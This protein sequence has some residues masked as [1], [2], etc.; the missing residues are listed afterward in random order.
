MAEPRTGPKFG[1]PTFKCNICSDSIHRTPRSAST[2]SQGSCEW[3]KH[4][5][6]V[7]W[8]K[9]EQIL[10]LKVGCP[11]FGPV[12]DSVI[13]P[14]YLHM[15]DVEWGKLPLSRT[16]P[17]SEQSTLKCN[18]CSNFTNRTW[19]SWMTKP[20]TGFLWMGWLW[21]CSMGRIEADIALES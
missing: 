3:F 1:Q 14:T 11:N 8:V 13:Y 15:C 6:E 5:C 16:V 10:Q 19:R 21:S 9:L 12:R 4:N 20:F 2:R 18:I 7:P 17:K